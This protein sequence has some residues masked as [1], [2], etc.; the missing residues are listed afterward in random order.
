[1][2]EHDSAWASGASNDRVAGQSTPQEHERRQEPA[3]SAPAAASEQ[4]GSAGYG[5]GSEAEAPTTPLTAGAHQTPG[6]PY[7]AP[8]TPYQPS[9]A[10]YQTSGAPYHQVGAPYQAPIGPGGPYGGGPYPGAP[11]PGAPGWQ[12]ATPPPNSGSRVARG[13]VIGVAAVALALFSGV[14]GGFVAHQFDRSAPAR[15]VTGSTV[16][17]SDGSVAAVAASV[18]P[19]VVDITT[20]SGEG[21][22]VVFSADG[23]ILTNNHVLEGARGNS[24]EV[25]FSN[26]KTA[27]ATIVGTD[28]AG[29]LALVKAQGVS[30]LTPARFGDS[31]AVQVGDTVL[32]LGS[33]LGLQG[34]VTAGIV[35]ALHRTID[36]G[37]QSASGPGRSIGDAI[38]TDAAINPG[39]SGGPLVNIK[40]DVIGINTAILT[41]GQGSAGNIGVGF[42]ISSNRAKST[43]E[44]LRN[45]G[46]VSHPYLG[47]QVGNGSGGALITDVVAGGPADKAG[48]RK[49]DLVTKAGSR[50]VTD[51]RSLVGAIQAG[52]PGESIQLTIV[53]NGAEQQISATLGESP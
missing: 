43:A 24:V 53:R 14:T 15:T 41:S 37:G 6:E 23:Y 44:Q 25:T 13:V 48:L 46:K 34:S 45:G 22:G 31:D 11:Y 2:S 29:D 30:D 26:G 40:G 52:K 12:P 8:G 47:V 16:A 21:S 5:G 50:T 18:Q 9:G 27:K 42:A 35:S 36:E 3:G 1:M 28:P 19:S 7:R 38:Q 49:G 10:P 4:A 33:P 20:G 32:A 39:N 51:S 17:T